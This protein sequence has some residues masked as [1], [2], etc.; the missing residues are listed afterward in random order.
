M[1]EAA[2]LLDGV[3]EFAKTVGEFDAAGIELEALG[4]ARIFR[5]GRASAACTAGYSS[6]MVARP[7]P[8]L[9]SMRSTST[10]LKISPQ[11]SSSAMRMPAAC[12]APR[13][14]LAVGLAVRQ[15]RQQ[16]D[17]GEARERF[18]DGQPLRL[19]KRIG[20]AAAKAELL[21]SRRLAPLAPGSR[22]SPPSAPDT[23]RRRDTIRPA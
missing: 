9:G 10:R 5:A 6:R 11:R 19:G 17:A 2:A 8:R 15:R 13:K 22:R 4:D 7:M 16:I 1:F 21:R 3:G 12:A 18:G 23:A 20:R 14:A